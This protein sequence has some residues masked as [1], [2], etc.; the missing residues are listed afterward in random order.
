[1]GVIFGRSGPAYGSFGNV[2]K[3]KPAVT[4]K[5]EEATKIIDV[6]EESVKLAEKKYA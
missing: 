2:L 4:L 6:F 1:L 3:M 5:E